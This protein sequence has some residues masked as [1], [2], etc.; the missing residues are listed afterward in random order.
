MG[1]KFNRV[2]VKRTLTK[3]KFSEHFVNL[4]FICGLVEWFF[5]YSFNYADK[6]FILFF[7]SPDESVELSFDSP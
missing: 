1:T 5:P 3:P 6:I 7:V 2:T 4:A